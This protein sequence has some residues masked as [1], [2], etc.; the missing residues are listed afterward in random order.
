MERPSRLEERTLPRVL[1]TR[2]EPFVLRQVEQFCDLKRRR[3]AQATRNDGRRPVRRRMTS[4]GLRD[5]VTVI[6][7]RI[8]PITQGTRYDWFGKDA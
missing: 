7:N 4:L 5:I 2:Q 1:S 6:R 3:P 8:V